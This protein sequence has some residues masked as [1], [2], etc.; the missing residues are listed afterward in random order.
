[1]VGRWRDGSS[2]GIQTTAEKSM[3]GVAGRSMHGVL[4]CRREQQMVKY[5]SEIEKQ[6]A[7]KAKVYALCSGGA[8]KHE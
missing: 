8:A 6:N 4:Q 2:R 5:R 7:F 1:M 3:H